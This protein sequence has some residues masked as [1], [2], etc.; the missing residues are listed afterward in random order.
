MICGFGAALGRHLNDLAI[1]ALLQL[2]DKPLEC[3]KYDLGT[4]VDTECGVYVCMCV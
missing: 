3:L 4:Q 1:K 2:A